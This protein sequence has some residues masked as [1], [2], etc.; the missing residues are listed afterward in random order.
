MGPPNNWVM[1]KRHTFTFGAEQ[2][3]KNGNGGKESMK[4]VKETKAESEA[5]KAMKGVKK[6]T[7]PAPTM[8][9]KKAMK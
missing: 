1:M 4:G 3:G 7:A 2:K 5:T 9:A 8:K 6:A